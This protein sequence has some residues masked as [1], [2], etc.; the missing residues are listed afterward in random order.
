M[1]IEPIMDKDRFYF[2]GQ[3]SISTKHVLADIWVLKASDLGVND[4]PIHT[5]THLGHV[6]KP[7]D[8]VLGY[9]IEDSNIND[10]HFDKLDKNVVPDVILVKKYYDRSVSRRRRLWKLKHLAEQDTDLAIDNRDY[11]EFLDDLEEDPDLRQHVNIFKDHSKQIPVDSGEEVDESVP[12]ITLAEMLDD[13]V[14]DDVEMGET[15]SME[16]V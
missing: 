2:P 9:N 11:N 5:R 1:D 8:S 16:N 12:Q 4:N 13:L 14:I 10:V 6:L 7:G 3:G 15:S